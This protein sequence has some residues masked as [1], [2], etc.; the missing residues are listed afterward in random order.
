MKVRH[1]T[2]ADNVREDGSLIDP[3]A[4]RHGMIVAG[5]VSALAGPVDPLTHLNADFDEHGLEQCAL[6]ERLE[7]GA[8]AIFGE[9]GLRMAWAADAD[10]QPLG[11]V[12]VQARLREWRAARAGAATLDA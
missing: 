12:D 3:L 9:D 7:L 5:R 1:L 4:V 10:Y 8:R 6:V 2:A 11:R